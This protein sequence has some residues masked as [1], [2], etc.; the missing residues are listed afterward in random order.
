MAPTTPVPSHVTLVFEAQEG[1][2][3]A[4]PP[5]ISKELPST[6]VVTEAPPRVVTYGR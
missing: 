6:A 5:I 2:Q 1:V 4:I 3:V